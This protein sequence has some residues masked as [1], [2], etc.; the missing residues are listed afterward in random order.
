MSEGIKRCAETVGSAFLV[1]RATAAA[2]WCRWV[3]TAASRSWA[4]CRTARPSVA[5]PATR[6]VTPAS[7]V[8]WC[9]SR[10]SPAS[11][12]GRPASTTTDVAFA[13]SHCHRSVQ[14]STAMLVSMCVCVCVCVCVQNCISTIIHWVVFDSRYSR[15]LIRHRKGRR[16]SLSVSPVKGADRGERSRRKTKAKPEKENEKKSASN[17]HSNWFTSNENEKQNQTKPTRPTE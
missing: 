8:S 13:L 16:R 9:G 17:L 5:R 3:A 6:R 12:R 4:S 7:P 2:P 11:T 10:C 1:I 15:I 14:S